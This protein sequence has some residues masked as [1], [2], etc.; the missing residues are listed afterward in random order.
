MQ[1][2]SNITPERLRFDFNFDRKMTPEEIQKVS[3]IVNDAI[4]AKID[5]VCEEIPYEQAKQCGAIGVFE[6]KYGEIVK[7]YRIDGVSTEM[8][9]GPHVNNTGDIGG[10]RI[11]KEESSAAGVR[12]IKAVVG[13]F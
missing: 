13:N 6:G 11:Q 3:D 2:G 5:V 8:C 4:K 7:V 9:G 12:R 10:F 1:K